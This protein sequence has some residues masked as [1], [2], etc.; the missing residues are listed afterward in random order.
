M[1]TVPLWMP[2]SLLRGNSLMGSC[3]FGNPDGL[4]KRFWIQL[5]H[6]DTSAWFNLMEEKAKR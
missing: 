4:L 1:M 3:S 6:V 2:R 5:L